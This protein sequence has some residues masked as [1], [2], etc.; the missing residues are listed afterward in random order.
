MWVYFSNNPQGRSTG[1]CVLRAL[2]KT[3]NQTWEQTYI[4]LSTKGFQM[5]DW[6][7]SNPVW[8]SYLRDK[9]FKRFVIPNTCPDC[10]TIGDFA[11]EHPTGTYIVATGTHVVCI[12]DERIYDSWNSESEIPTHYYSKE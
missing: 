1:D 5:G 4:D 8:D 2:S 10:Y 7:N 11:Y 6:G 9:G 3:L 12:Q